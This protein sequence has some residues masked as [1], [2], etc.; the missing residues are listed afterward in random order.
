[1]LFGCFVDAEGEERRTVSMYSPLGAALRAA[2]R[3]ILTT[4]TLLI[5]CYA[6]FES[7]VM[8]NRLFAERETRM[9]LT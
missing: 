2:G 7:S 5:L 1:M 9:W 8:I 3:D 4:D 6:F